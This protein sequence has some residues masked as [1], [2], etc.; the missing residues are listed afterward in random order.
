MNLIHGDKSRICIIDYLNTYDNNRGEFR[1]AA[2]SLN[3]DFWSTLCIY[4]YTGMF[5][6]AIDTMLPLDGSEIM[7]S[8]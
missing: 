5:S 4:S 6:E 2:E 8:P 1:K 3:R 7:K